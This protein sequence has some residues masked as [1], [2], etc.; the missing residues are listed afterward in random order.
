MMWRDLR[1]NTLRLWLN[2][3]E[4]RP[5]PGA[6]DLSHFRT[7]YVDSGLIKDARANGVTTLLLAPDKLPPYMSE[8]NNIKDDQVEPYAALIADFLAQLQKETGITLGVT[9]IQNEP[10]NANNGP[11]IFSAPQLV[12]A[13][14]AL[15]V[16]LDKRGLQSVKIIAPETGSPDN[17]H[18]TFMNALQADPQAWKSLA[19]AASHSYNMAANSDAER[20]VAGANGRNSKE[21]WMTEASDN[22]P[23]NPGDIRRAV[24]LSARFLNDANHRVTNWIHFLGFDINDPGDNAT[25]IIAYTVNPAKIT[26]FKKYYAYQQLAQAFDVGTVFRN[27]TSSI[28]GDMTWTFGLKPRVI[29]ST[30][31][32]PDGSWSIGLTN[33]TADSFSGVQGGD[34]TW[35]REQGGHS[36][37]QN[38]SVTIRVDELKN[39][40]A[41]PFTVVRTNAAKSNAKS[42]TVV[43]RGGQVT[44]PIA[45]QELVTLRS[46]ALR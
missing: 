23:E 45:S 19:G 31:R 28:D 33:Y 29:S 10:N 32:N 30:A 16:E 24:S 6:H 8:G 5:T 9:G 13:V 36:P 34:E 11:G 3:D 22:G 14:K 27:S 37:A 40:P 39:R 38:Y 4:Y 43:M 42:E 20:Y 12:R 15:R 26:V 21:Y 44:V 18:N 7:M 2:T 35:N 17:V 1:F 41:V 46:T 25:R